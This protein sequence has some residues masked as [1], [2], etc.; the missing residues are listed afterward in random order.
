MVMDHGFSRR[1]FLGTTLMAAGAAGAGESGR[2]AGTDPMERA[3]GFPMRTKTRDRILAGHQAIRDELKPTKTQLDRGL[4]LHYDSFVADTLGGISVTWPGALTGDRLAAAT[5]LDRQKA[6][7]FQAVFDPQWVAESRALYEIAGVQLAAECVAHPG[8]GTFD[9]A[10][11]LLARSSFVYERRPDLD[12]V[13]S[14]ETI[15]RGRRERR[16]CVI[17]QLA[18][19]GCFADAAEPLINLDLFYALGVR[20]SQLTYI[21]KNSLGCSWLQ[22]DDT[23]LTELGGRIVRRMNQLGMIVDLAHCGHRT[24]HDVIA[25]AEAP[26]LVSHTGCKTVYDDASNET[27]INA[28]L[29]QAYAEGVPRPDK[30]GSRHIADDTLRALAAKGG[31]VGFYVIHYMLDQ[32]ASRSF[33]AWF[34]HIAHAIETVGIDHVAI[35]T[36]V[37]FFP[38]WTPSPLDWSNWPYFTVGLVCRGLSDDEIRKVIGGNYLGYL[39][40]VMKRKPWGEFI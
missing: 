15:D 20:M 32:Q 31:L 14:L 22:Y 12:R 39:Q 8:Y 35:G 34:R 40:K 11:H 1:S 19:V 28:V 13:A 21:Q 24:S 29:R 17:Q 7:T 36:D 23:G 4:Q 2:P 6:V 27:Y 3:A 18:D 16:P 10:L 5:D 38:G 25:A 30:T 37:T 9:K 33:D 26:P